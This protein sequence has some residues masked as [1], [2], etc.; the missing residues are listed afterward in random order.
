MLLIMIII[1][2]NNLGVTDEFSNTPLH[3]ASWGGHIE[4]VQY[5]VDECK[6]KTGEYLGA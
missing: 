6:C 5:L 1:V 4:V 2:T 3:Y